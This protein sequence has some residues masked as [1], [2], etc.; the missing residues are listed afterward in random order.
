MMNGNEYPTAEEIN[1]EIQTLEESGDFP[2]IYE[3]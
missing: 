3:K 2:E 1:A